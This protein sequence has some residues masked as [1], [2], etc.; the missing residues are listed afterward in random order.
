MIENF[1]DLHRLRLADD[2]MA[3]RTPTNREGGRT[4]SRATRVRAEFLKGPIPLDWLGRA[5]KLSGKAPLATALAIMF[6]AGRRRSTEITLTMAVLER[7]GVSRKAKYRALKHL[8][9]AGLI[10]VHQEPRRNPVVRV[11]DVK[12]HSGA[13]SCP[14][15][16]GG[17]T[18]A[19]PHDDS[20]KEPT[21]MQEGVEAVA[22]APEP[23]AD[24]EI[25]ER[26]ESREIEAD[27]TATNSATVVM[28]AA[29]QNPPGGSTVTDEHE[30]DWSD[31]FGPPI[32]DELWTR[33]TNEP[34]KPIAG[35][36]LTAQLEEMGVLAGSPRVTE[37]F[38]YYPLK[39]CPFNVE[40]RK[41]V[42][43]QHRSGTLSYLCPHHSCRGLKQGFD[44]KTARDFF[45]HYGVSIPTACRSLV[46]GQ[47]ED[48]T[49]CV[50]VG[51]TSP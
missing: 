3:T 12:E 11:L 46:G 44:R 40:H 5:A 49:E 24:R 4:R 28:G 41:V 19:T 31:V 27:L 43:S 13:D 35:F 6:E 17:A 39:E 25:V 9:S 29:E 16:V 22:S 7:F 21:D 2:Q 48:D 38:T 1:P 8:Q 10:A 30:A 37:V 23:P 34:L 47:H 50:A 14:R 32:T 20:P 15:D 36:D 42:L 26:V 45:G 33:W 51:C 18:Q